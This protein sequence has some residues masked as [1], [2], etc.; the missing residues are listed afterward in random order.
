MVIADAAERRHA[1][2]TG[3]S[4]IVQAPAGSGKTELL[5]QRVLA[6]LATVE[7]PEEVVAITFT[8]KAAAEMRARVHGAIRR[9][10][11]EPAPAEEHARQTWEL[12]SR[13]LERSRELDWA[14][15]QSP[16]RLRITTIDALCASLVQQ[17]PVLSR[18]GGTLTIAQDP[19]ALYRDASRETLMQIDGGDTN[20]GAVQRVLR[21]YDNQVQNLEKHLAELLARRDQWLA[22][23]LDAEGPQR[24]RQLLEALLREQIEH[25]LQELQRRL[26]PALH[27]EWLA[28]ARYAGNNLAAEDPSHPL[29]LLGDF[30]DLA[31]DANDLEN[32]Q[33]L[34]ELVLT[35]QDGWRQRW[36][37]TQ[38]F[39]P[40]R[41]EA[42]DWKRRM[43]LLV[44]GLRLAGLD[45]LLSRLRRLPPPRYR[46]SQWQ[47]LQALL[48]TLKL[49][50]L[51]LQLAFA[52]RGE[53]DFIEVARQAVAALGDEDA[54]TD[55]ALRLDY[56]VRH[57]LVDEFQDT[58]A[59][60]LRLLKSLT[61]GWQ[62]GDGRTLFLVGDPMQ[63]IYRFREAEVGLFLRTQQQPLGAVQLTPLTL[64]CN[65][66]S[67]PALVDWYN[68]A[69]AQVLPATADV[70]LGAVPY[71]AAIAAREVQADADAQVHASIDAGAAAEGAQIAALIRYTQQREPQAGIAILARSRTHLEGI[72]L[73][74][75]AAGIRYQAIDIEGLSSRPVIDDLRALTRALLHPGDRL[76]WLAVLRAPWCGLPLAALQKLAQPAREDAPLLA[77]LRQ[78]RF[79]GEDAARL[80]RVA[81]VF[82]ASLAQRGRKRLRRWVEDAWLALDGPACVAEASDLADAQRFFALLDDVARGGEL[83][84]LAA[85]DRALEE[86]KATP[87][88]DAA[89]A[90]Q[91][92]TIHR[93]KGLE[94]DH[95][96]VPSLH[97]LPGSE[98]KPPLAWTTLAG[99]G[100]APDDERF[101][102]AP[103]GATGGDEDPVYALIRGLEAQKRGHEDGR[104]LYVAAT[105]ARK[106]LHLFGSVNAT[107]IG[108]AEPPSA[109]LLAQLWPAVSADFR[110]AYEERAAPA[111]P[112]D[113]PP[114][115]EPPPLRRLG[116]GWMPPAPGSDLA[117]SRA[118]LLSEVQQHIAFDWAGHLARTVGTVAHRWLQH[119]AETGA[120][121]W[122][123]ARIAGLAG[124][125]ARELALE[126]LS[127]EEST[128]AS[129]RVLEALR[130][131]LEDPRG[132]WI[133]QEHAQARCEL[134]LS[135]VGGEGAVRQWRVDRSFVDADG[136]RW[137][138]DYKTSEH[139][140]GGEEEFL[141]REQERY[142]GQLENYA[143]LFA[144][145]ER[146]PVKLGLYFPLLRAWRSWD[147][148][149]I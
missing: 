4:F 108:P 49:A 94:F 18:L 53:V 114:S 88:A 62:A 100:D 17:S 131:S 42:Q 80:D 5:T 101:L 79:E 51:Q 20:A 133:L 87:D 40:G 148:A 105:R 119:V 137:I 48:Q 35:N 26:S 15:E 28:L 68:R 23:A 37:R 123:T 13:A 22:L 1:L 98:D 99:D 129:Q 71:S 116:A 124:A 14:L 12:A 8:R 92:M 66:R 65:F 19:R 10:A 84:G 56:R 75:R 97:R 7:Q 33:A 3:T 136:T 135:G 149:S 31:T 138:I 117:L 69:F 121:D 64:R 106:Q 78:V 122:S 145:I 2:D 70:E 73:A 11:T 72:V 142:R 104:L 118:P 21:H 55:L 132:R 60:Q 146:R 93:A 16:Q 107:D 44:A 6:L 141:D 82:D 77:A 25:M 43:E 130:N 74:L 38:G 111:S 29:A 125:V 113:A 47:V 76:A 115:R 86:L 103:V 41:S 120:Q 50:A 128:A 63:S 67:A 52:A 9:A 85:L 83:P 139:A 59:L 34:L 134:V 36:T 109:S 96:I 24:Q 27:A 57:L 46:D 95:V 91:I 54:P 89:G 61:A 112:E 110:R 90:V 144:Q 32:W 140:G 143:R 127:P 30:Q 126:G 81:S 102:A 45:E 39:P 58:S 147:A